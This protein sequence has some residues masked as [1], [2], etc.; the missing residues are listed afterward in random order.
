ME[1]YEDQD[2]HYYGIKKIC[3]HLHG[4]QDIRELLEWCFILCVC[5]CLNVYY[6]LNE[7]ERER[8]ERKFGH[9]SRLNV[10]LPLIG[11]FR[12]T[13]EQKRG[14]CYFIHPPLVLSLDLSGER[15]GESAAV[16]CALD[17]QR[18]SSHVNRKQ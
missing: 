15:A 3:T 13:K 16:W 10:Q 4:G 18:K 2:W 12:G 9:L 1:S 5:V 6:A 8:D 11:F 7:L 14:Q 17:V